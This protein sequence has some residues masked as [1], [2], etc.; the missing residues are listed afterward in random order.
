MLMP[1]LE[2]EREFWVAFGA[3][4]RRRVD[5][6]VLE[7]GQKR[8]SL[9]LTPSLCR[10]MLKKVVILRRGSVAKLS[11]PSFLYPAPGT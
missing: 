10:C 8:Q 1:L 4:L 3:V 11:S 9:V 6:P 2:E 5:L 7:Q